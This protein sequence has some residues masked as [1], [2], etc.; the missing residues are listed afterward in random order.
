[1]DWK[2]FCTV[3]VAAWLAAE[4]RDWT[5]ILRDWLIYKDDPAA[6]WLHRVGRRPR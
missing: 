3:V 2:L 1:M 6:E 4:I 5:R